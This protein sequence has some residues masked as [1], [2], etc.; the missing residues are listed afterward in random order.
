MSCGLVVDPARAGELAQHKEKLMEVCIQRSK[1]FPKSALF[2]A[3]AFAAS[4]YFAVAAPRVHGIGA[5][6][7]SAQQKVPL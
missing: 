4:A 5:T 6:A 7:R 1:K 3:A 2:F